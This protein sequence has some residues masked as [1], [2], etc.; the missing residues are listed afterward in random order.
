MIDRTKNGMYMDLDLYSM[1]FYLYITCC[2]L[3]LYF[4]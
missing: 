2:I 3:A 1:F 4:I